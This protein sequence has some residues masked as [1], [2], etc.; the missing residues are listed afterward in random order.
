MCGMSYPVSD[1]IVASH[2]ELAEQVRSIDS[3][4]AERGQEPFLLDSMAD[5]LS[6]K[7]GV[8]SRVLRLYETEGAVEQV[9]VFLCPEDGEFLEKN[10]EGLLWCDLCEGEYSADECQSEMAYRLLPGF[11]PSPPLLRRLQ[12]APRLF[13]SYAREDRAEAE[14]LY[15]KLQKAGLNPW[16]DTKDILPGE[17]WQVS[18]Q[19]AIRSS[20]F[21]LACLSR[22]S[23]GKR[24]WIQ[25]EI[26][27]ALDT[28]EE[29]L[30]SDIYLIPV[31]L[32][33]CDVPDRLRGFQWVDLYADDGLDRLLAAIQSGMT[34][35]P[36]KP[37]PTPA[38]ANMPQISSLPPGVVQQPTVD[39]QVRPAPIGA[40]RELLV[41]GFTAEDFKRLFLFSSQPDLR[42]VQN[43]FSP[44]DGLAAMVDKALLCYEKRGLLRV[45]LQE[46]ER[47]NPRQ[48]AKY[49][50]SL[51][52]LA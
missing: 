16:M 5:F 4:L 38:S 17:Q 39:G 10:E 2:P 18:I 36:P 22:R 45:L 26:K 27:R 24:G 15:R 30:D 20:D 44:S 13:L 47:A 21:F 11:A 37:S 33:D 48:Y 25:K 49:K 6:M 32:E 7:L 23:V 12:V 1:T 3:Y 9:E 42:G 46:V 43:E 28:W 29:M 52:D 34:R 51:S 14:H 8:L 40:M 19:N 35:R 50:D 31:R 41:A